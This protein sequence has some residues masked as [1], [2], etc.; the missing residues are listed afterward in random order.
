MEMVTTVPVIGIV[1]A[2]KLFK[3]RVTRDVINRTSPSSDI[4]HVYVLNRPIASKTAAN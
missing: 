2:P 4:E 3:D 1:F